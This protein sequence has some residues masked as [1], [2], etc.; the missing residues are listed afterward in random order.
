MNAIT[1]KVHF[2]KMHFSGGGVPIDGWPSKT[3]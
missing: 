3:I 1:G 2:Q